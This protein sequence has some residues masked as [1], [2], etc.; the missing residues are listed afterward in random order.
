MVDGSKV[1]DHHAV[2]PTAE[3]AAADLNT[4]PTG[5]RNILN[6]I[7]VRLLCAVGESHTYA[8]TA[9]TVDCGGV[10]FSAKGCTVTAG[11]WK[12]IEKAFL[13][14]LKEKPKQENIAFALPKLSEGQQLNCQGKGPAGLSC[15][16]AC[17]HRPYQPG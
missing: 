12:A 14:T 8:E 9:V 13:S 1:T 5:E 2:I 17:R 7:A 15:R 11:G 16:K 6:L 4:L 3:I 10:P